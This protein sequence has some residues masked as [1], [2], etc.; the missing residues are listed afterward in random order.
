MRLTGRF[1]GVA[2]YL[3][4]AKLALTVSA[5]PSH[6]DHVVSY[7]ALSQW[8]PDNQLY[9]PGR[10]SGPESYLEPADGIHVLG[11]LIKNSGV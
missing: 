10:T 3:S 6:C 2:R 9:Y 8:Q 5:T 1:V 11:A 4:K 7:L